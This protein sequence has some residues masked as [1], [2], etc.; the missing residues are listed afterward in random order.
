MSFG[1]K[2]KTVCVRQEAINRGLNIPLMDRCK[3]ASNIELWKNRMN[4]RPL[5]KMLNE[6]NMNQ[7]GLFVGQE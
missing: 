4:V 6:H 5:M 2:P 3:T 7:T 1:S